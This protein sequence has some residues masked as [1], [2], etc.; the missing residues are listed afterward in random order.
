MN[1]LINTKELSHIL[2]RKPST[3]AR[4]WRDWANN[5]FPNPV[6]GFEPKGRPRWLLSDIEAYLQSLRGFG[7]MANDNNKPMPPPQIVNKQ[8]DYVDNGVISDLLNFG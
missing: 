2:A 4:S 6:T 7:G 3:I 5:G 1:R 8:T